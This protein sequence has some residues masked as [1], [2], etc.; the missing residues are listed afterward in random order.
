MRSLMRPAIRYGSYFILGL[1]VYTN[2]MN[3]NSRTGDVHLTLRVRSQNDDD[4]D[5]DVRAGTT[6]Y[7]NCAADRPGTGRS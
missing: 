4:D 2:I 6:T 7:G 1:R 5:D 3:T